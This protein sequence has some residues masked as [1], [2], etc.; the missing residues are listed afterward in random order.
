MVTAFLTFP[1]LS[2]FF[3]AAAVLLTVPFFLPV[4]PATPFLLGFTKYKD[5]SRSSCR[6]LFLALDLEALE[7]MTDW[8]KEWRPEF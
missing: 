1:T 4:V 8:S 6:Y 5:Y 7:S 3:Y 2:S